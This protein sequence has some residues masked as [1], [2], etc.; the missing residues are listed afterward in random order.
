[1]PLLFYDYIKIDTN[2]VSF[3]FLSWRV[4][5]I[6]TFS[7]LPSMGSNLSCTKWTILLPK[8]YLV[9][10][11]CPASVRME[12]NQPKHSTRWQ[13]LSW[14]KA[15]VFF[16]FKKILLLWNT[17][18]YTWDWYCHLV[19]DRASSAGWPDVFVK[20]SQK[21]NEKSPK[22]LPNHVFVRFTI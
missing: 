12:R 13:H 3:N 1:M 19:G 8:K 4:I 9:R 15:S 2:A 7:E 17:A 14:L 11:S 6:F 20:K 10:L 16:S 22:K 18:T 21:D 5:I